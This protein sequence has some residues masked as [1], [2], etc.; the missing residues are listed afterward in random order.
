MF[1]TACD[2]DIIFIDKSIDEIIIRL[3]DKERR[4]WLGVSK[5]SIEKS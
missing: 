3:F 1:V 5:S 2:E 4:V